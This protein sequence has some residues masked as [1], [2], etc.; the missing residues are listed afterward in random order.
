MERGARAVAEL[1][2]EHHAQTVRRLRQHDDVIGGRRRSRQD[3][4][5]QQGTEVR[6]G[7]IAFAR[8]AAEFAISG[9]LHLLSH[10]CAQARDLG[11]QRVDI[12]L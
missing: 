10:A 9:H 11:A 2:V 4:A 3:F 7:G 1:V 5:S 8:Q 6:H 12:P